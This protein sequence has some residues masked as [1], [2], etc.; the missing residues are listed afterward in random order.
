MRKRGATHGATPKG[1]PKQARAPR[2]LDDRQEDNP[3]RAAARTLL[4]KPD[5]V[6][7]E[8]QVA[9]ASVYRLIAAGDLPVVRVGKRIRVPFD[10]LV[11]WIKAN[12]S[13]G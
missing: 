10:S 4:L 5:D 7:R 12:E 13:G 11:A 2:E 8:L 6:A 3:P 1:T 9:R